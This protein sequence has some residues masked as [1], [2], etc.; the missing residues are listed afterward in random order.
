MTPGERVLIVDD[1]LATGGTARAAANLVERVGGKDSGAAGVGEHRRAARP[2]Q[3][4]RA[5]GHRDVEQAFNRRRAED[6]GLREHRIHRHVAHAPL[7]RELG[8][9]RDVA[10]LHRR[11]GRGFEPQHAGLRPDR[12]CHRVGL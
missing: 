7:M 11:V 8:Q 9:R 12:R 1:V 2:R 5:E 10:Q 4:A 6:A 3:C